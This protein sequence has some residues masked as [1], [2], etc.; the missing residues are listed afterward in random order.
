MSRAHRLAPAA[1][2]LA[3]ALSP[4][5]AAQSQAQAHEAAVHAAAAPHRADGGAPGHANHS[6]HASHSSHSGHSGRPEHPEHADPSHHPAHSAPRS[7]AD[8]AGGD[9]SHDHAGHAAAAA[10]RPGEGDDATHAPV[11]L[12]TAADRAAA[13]PVL[14]HPHAHAPGVHALVR[15]DRLEAW[16]AGAGHGQAWEGT[17]WI[18]GD[19]QRLWLRSAGERGHGRTRAADVEALYGRAVSP[20]WD[21]L[22]GVRHDI[23]PGPSRTRLA[24]G[25]QGL[26]P[27]KFEVAATAYV[28]ADGR[29]AVEAEVEYELLFTSRLILQP[30]LEVELQGRDDPRR[31]VAA[32][33]ASA[34]AALRLRYEVTRRFAPYVGVVH[35]R[36][37][38]GTA[39]LHRAEGE[40]VRDTRWVAG[41]RAW[42]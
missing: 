41:V 3:L 19:V 7:H 39:D 13:F 18:G 25:V 1:L 4:P 21:L 37:F 20:W 26:A 28:D 35:E 15:M 6:G 9:A 2:A 31:G 42:F 30:A 10:T 32:G 34:E 14:R 17:A 38:G 12:P 40:P 16:D 36:A 11:P 27:Y 5:A 33:L 22:A 24:L 29:A 23:V 8:H